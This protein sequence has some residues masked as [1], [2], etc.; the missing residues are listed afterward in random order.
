MFNNIIGGWK[1]NLNIKCM[2]LP[3]FKD[4]VIDNNE[5]ID[6]HRYINNSILRIHRRYI[7]RYFGKKFDK[8]KIYEN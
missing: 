5:N 3:P 6:N 4:M 7:G 8:L 2:R 1:D